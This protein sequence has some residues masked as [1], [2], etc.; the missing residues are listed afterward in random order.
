MN[1]LISII[2][3][4]KNGSNYLA[5]ALTAIQKQ[6]M[7]IEIIVVDDASTDNT[8]EI[9]K[10]FG[11]IVLKH[12]VSKGPVIAKNSALKIAKGEYIMFH[13]HDDI[14][15]ENSLTTLLEELEKDKNASAVMAKVQD[16]ISEEVSQEIKD[17]TS[18]KEEAYYGLFTGA[19]LMRKS[20]FEKIGFFS[21]NITAGEIIEW[22]ARMQENNLEIKKLGYI[23]CN[24]RIHDTNYGKTN[25]E[26][27]YKD[28]SSILRAKLRKK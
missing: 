25:Q 11:C 10:E 1:K 8:A 15:N 28:Y 6:E 26:K 17:K 19:I 13:D 7:N 27:E 21:E 18:M 2:I 12:E 23:T 24:R 9:A 22:Q 16:F 4:C 5:Y 20:I 14:M 3:P